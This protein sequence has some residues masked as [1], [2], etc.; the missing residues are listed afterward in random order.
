MY[1]CRKP[2]KTGLVLRVP[3]ACE[4]E[5][6]QLSSRHKTSVPS[7]SVPVYHVV[8]VFFFV[9][10]EVVVHLNHIAPLVPPFHSTAFHSTRGLGNGRDFVLSR[11]DMGLGCGTVHAISPSLAGRI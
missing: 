11:R 4:K 1:L 7:V 3:E 10:L 9:L 5:F 8:C 6:L 2:L